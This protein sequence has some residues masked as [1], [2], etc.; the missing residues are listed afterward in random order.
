VKRSAGILLWRRGTAG[1]EVFLAHPGGPLFARKDDAHWSVPKGEHEP[2]ES[3][4]DAAWREFAEE[5]GHP[6][7]AGTVVE[8]GEAKQRGG[9]INTVYAVEGDLDPAACHSN[10]FSMVW[11]GRLQRFPEMDRYAWYD[12]ETARAKLFGSQ[13]VFVDRL[14]SLLDDPPVP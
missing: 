9:K 12:L 3:P 7:P 1:V 10:D 2:G 8:L 5:T 14:E 13:V 4:R 6:V 11:H